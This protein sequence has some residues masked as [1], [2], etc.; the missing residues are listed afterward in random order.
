M[1][2][3]FSQYVVTDFIASSAIYDLALNLSHVKISLAAI[4]TT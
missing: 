3:T 1:K 2:Y 4:V